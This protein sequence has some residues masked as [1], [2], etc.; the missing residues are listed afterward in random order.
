MLTYAEL[1][2]IA[3]DDAEKENKK[4]EK[5]EKK[6]VR[7]DPFLADLTPEQEAAYNEAYKELRAGV[8]PYKRKVFGRTVGLTALGGAALGGAGGLLSGAAS[9]AIAMAGKDLGRKLALG[10]LGGLAGGVG[11]AV[12][13]GL[14]GAAA[15]IVPGL[16]AH[17]ASGEM[18]DRALRRR[19]RAIALKKVLG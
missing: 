9:G 10:T 5:A 1:V 7:K 3:A 15:G 19:A 8:N 6:R 2:K 18:E 17:L 16:V 14:S 12:A 13:G 11:G 4:K